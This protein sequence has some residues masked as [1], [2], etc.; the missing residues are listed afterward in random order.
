[1]A[2]LFL[3]CGPE[4][5]FVLTFRCGVVCDSGAISE[6]AIQFMKGNYEA[7][8]EGSYLYHFPFQLGMIAFLELLYRLL[9]V[10]N[11]LVFQV[12]NILA[13]TGIVRCLQKIT[14][15]LFEKREYVIWKCCFPWECFL[16][17]Y[18]PLWS[19]GM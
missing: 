5:L 3:G 13:I 15:L 10:E 19:T 6:Y 11:F 17:T 9:G 2:F 4:Q 18:M 7:F 1:M 12:I 16:F 8:Q 14:G